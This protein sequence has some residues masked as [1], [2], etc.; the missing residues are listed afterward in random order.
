MPGWICWLCAGLAVLLIMA[1]AILVRIKRARER[2][3]P[4]DVARRFAA[5]EEQA[6][7]YYRGV[8]AQL[9]LLGYSPA[10]GETILQFAR[11][12]MDDPDIRDQDVRDAFA[13]IM[14]ARYGRIPPPEDVLTRMA[15]IHARLENLLWRK[16][17]KISYFFKRVLFL[18]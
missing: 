6:D 1:V 3:R 17:N 2:Y 15:G 8:L 9:R 12:A 13:I 4:A 7:H 11:R 10:A 14:D 18:D 5:R 16:M